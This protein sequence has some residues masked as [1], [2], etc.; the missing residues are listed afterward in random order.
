MDAMMDPM[1]RIGR[2]PLLSGECRFCL[3]V[4]PVEDW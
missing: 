3:L 4:F 2:D 1:K